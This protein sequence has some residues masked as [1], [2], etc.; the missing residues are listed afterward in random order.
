MRDTETD[1]DTVDLRTPLRPEVGRL[2]HRPA[3]SQNVQLMRL[4][5]EV[6]V[7]ASG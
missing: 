5:H 3:G 7:V 2:G 1:V 6:D 4:K